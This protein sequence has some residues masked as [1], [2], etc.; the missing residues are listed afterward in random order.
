MSPH[1][2]HIYLLCQLALYLPSPP[3]L[4]RR[5]AEV[6]R[7]LVCRS[8][9]T[10]LFCWSS[11]SYR[12]LLNKMCC[13]LV[14]FFSFGCIS[15]LVSVLTAPDESLYYARFSRCHLLALWNLRLPFLLLSSSQPHLPVSTLSFYN[16]YSLGYG[17]TIPVNTAALRFQ[18]NRLV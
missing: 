15:E 2:H 1:T 16:V 9:C 10:S 3:G 11:S 18:R 7:L 4:V 17:G 8:T 14:Y 6:S 13:S 5:R 12:T